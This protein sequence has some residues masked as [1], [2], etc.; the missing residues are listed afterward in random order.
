MKAVVYSGNNSIQLSEVPEPKIESPSDV[1]IK[2]NIS[3]ICASDIHVREGGLQDT[4]KI[5]GHEYAGV[6][7]EVGKEVHYLKRGD[8]VI[9]KPFSHCGHC[10]YCQH[11]QPEICEN[12]SIFGVLGGTGVQTE[13]A[14]IPWAENILKI[15]PADLSFE[16]VIFVGDILSTGFTGMLRGHLNYGETVAVFGTGPVG[17]CAVATAHLFGPNKVIAV[18]TLD[19]RLNVASKFGALTI[20]A[21]KEDPVARIKELTSGRGVDLGVEAAGFEATFNSCLK[22]VRRGGR[23]SIVGMFTKPT[24]FNISERFLDLFNLS[25]GLGDCS[26]MGE[27]INLIEVESLT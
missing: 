20:N 1:I 5:I 12:L 10:F 15:V 18:D 23:I 14:K 3:S 16:D 8:R 24:Y 4:G 6:I 27:L 25:I 9:G 22:S 17:L 21:S 11:G 26:H 7:E 13:Y 19:Y 2:I